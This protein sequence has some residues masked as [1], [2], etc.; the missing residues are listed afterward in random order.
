VYEKRPKRK[1]SELKKPYEMLNRAKPLSDNNSWA[2]EVQR[3]SPKMKHSNRKGALQKTT[4][5]NRRRP[6]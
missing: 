2:E 1:H 5:K 6:S 3:K 4:E